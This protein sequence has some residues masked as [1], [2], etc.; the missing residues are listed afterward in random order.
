MKADSNWMRRAP[1]FK[2]ILTCV[3]VGL[4]LS[5]ITF[6]PLYFLNILSS[7]PVGV[8]SPVRFNKNFL[9]RIFY[10][11]LCC[12]FNYLSKPR[13]GVYQ[14]WGHIVQLVHPYSLW[15]RGAH[16][17]F[18]KKSEC[19]KKEKDGPHW[20]GVKIYEEKEGGKRRKRRRKKPQNINKFTKERR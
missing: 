5:S 3:S 12:V 17:G 10:S 19:E 16:A 4:F 20:P 11:S 8:E 13:K 2:L 9:E 18:E 14:S 6:L 15:Y 1:I 7:R